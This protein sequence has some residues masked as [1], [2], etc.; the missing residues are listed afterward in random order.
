MFKQYFLPH[1]MPP[2]PAVFGHQNAYPPRGWGMLNNSVL[3]DCAVAGGMHVCQLWRQVINKPI[4]FTNADARQD[5]FAITG[6]GDDGMDMVTM[7]KYWQNIGFRDSRNIRHKILAYL[8]VDGTHL[9][10]VDTAAYLFDAVGLGISVGQQ[11]MQEF[12]YRQPWANPN[13]IATGYHYVPMVGKDND[14]RYVVTWGGLQAVTEAWLK[15]KVNEVVAVLSDENLIA[16]R[17]LEGF[18]MDALEA[19]LEGVG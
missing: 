17:S 6:G 14:Y 16:G 5:Y 3:G 4:R 1:L 13:S 11:E 9:E 8:H 19:D 2:V 7:A 10:R 15:A 12:T 18:D